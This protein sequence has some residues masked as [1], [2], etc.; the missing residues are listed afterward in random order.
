MTEIMLYN[1]ILYVTGDI[2]ATLLIINFRCVLMVIKS[3]YPFLNAPHSTSF[4]SAENNSR[5]TP[6]KAGTATYD[7][8]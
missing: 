7:Y 8:F 2:G 3:F 4:V 6:Y 5:D 1:T